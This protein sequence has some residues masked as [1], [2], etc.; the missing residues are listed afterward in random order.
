MFDMILLY[1]IL[2]SFIVGMGVFVSIKYGDF[3]PQD[4]NQVQRSPTTD[5]DKRKLE[6]QY[7]QSENERRERSM[8]M[9]GAIFLPVSLLIM[10]QAFT[11][12]N[13]LARFALVILSI[14]LYTIW[15]F[16]VNLTTIS[17]NEITYKRLKG[18]EEQDD[19]QVHRYMY[20]ET[21]TEVENSTNDVSWLSNRRSH[22][23]LYLI[24]LYGLGATIMFIPIL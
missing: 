6:Y 3:L 1:V 10:G 8:I 20:A 16:R 19:F 18:I 13:I 4:T 2:G 17:L 22:W 24:L 15:L 21:R 12:D 14:G 11:Q 23:G 9:M 7:L 5:E